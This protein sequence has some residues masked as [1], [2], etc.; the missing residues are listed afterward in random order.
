M[1]MEALRL[2]DPTFERGVFIPAAGVPWFVTL[3]G[4]D[5]L[6][7][8]MQSI[9]GYPEFASGAL[10][11]LSQAPGHRRRPGTGH[12]AG[13][14]PARDPPRRAR[15]ARHPA[16]S[17]RTTARTT[18]RA[19]SSSC[20]RTSTTGWATTTSLRA[21]PAERRGRASTG[22]T[23]SAT[24]TATGS[25]S[26]RPARATATTTRAGRTPAT[27]SST[28]TARWRPCRSRSSSCRATSTTPSSGWR[29]IYDAPRPRR[30]TPPACGARPARLY[31]RVNE[32]FWWEAEGTYYLGL[33]GA[34]RPIESVASNPGHLLMS[35]IVPADRAKRV[36][37]RLMARRHVVGLGH[38]DA[39]V[40]P[41]RA[42]TRSATTRA[43]SGRT[44]TRSSP[45][46]FAHY[47][48]H[49]EA[50]RVARGIFDA[51]TGSRPTGCPSC[52]PAC[53]A[54]TAASRSSTSARTSPRPGRP[55]AII[56]LH[57]DPGRDPRPLG[58]GGSRLYV[59]PTLPDW[60]P[61]LTIDNLRAGR[62]RVDVRL[63]DGELGVLSNTTGFEVV[64]GPPGHDLPPP[65]AGRRPKARPTAT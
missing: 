61:G 27:R 48:F 51:A 54:R 37:E 2:E 64:H 8:S 28:P 57:R 31:E 36:V 24:A 9:A 35:G 44:T 65:Y 19:C 26:T 34:K 49:A 15:P 45:A 38:P 52:S 53:P 30:R 39:V 22:S 7:V 11:R 32:R 12:G 55:G 23:A 60:L 14:D 16:R 18:R 41:R 1:D 58:R 21:L 20:C 62:G 42:T 13:Q 63:G 43:R 5:S 10:R 50:A 46:G 17:R 40:R 56:R 6:I 33:D 25:R 47:G 3:F 29:R 4:R 59:N